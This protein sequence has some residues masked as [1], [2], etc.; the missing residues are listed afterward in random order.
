MDYETSW[1]I[2]QGTPNFPGPRLIPP[3]DSLLLISAPLPS[4]FY[5]I[6]SI[7]GFDLPGIRQVNALEPIIGFSGHC[8]NRIEDQSLLIFSNCQMILP[9]QACMLGGGRASLSI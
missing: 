9:G 8:R 2:L 6:T 4:V 3:L 1:F 7:P 5:T